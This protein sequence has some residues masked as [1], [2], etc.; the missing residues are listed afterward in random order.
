VQERVKVFV[1]TVE[2]ERACV[3]ERGLLPFQPEFVGLAEAVQE[4]AFAKLQVRETVAGE[5]VKVRVG[6][7][8]VEGTTVKIKL[9]VLESG[10]PVTVIVELPVGVE[11]VVLIVTVVEQ[12]GLQDVGEKLAVAPEGSPEAEYETDCLVSEES[13]A[14]IVFE[15]EEPWVA[16]MLPEEERE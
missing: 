11:A 10:E 5:G 7:G 4:V 2:T 1:P 12:V 6:G 9:V 14:A 15:P 13:V 8:V 3:P 16:A